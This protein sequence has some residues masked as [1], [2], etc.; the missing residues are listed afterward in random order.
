MLPP[1]ISQRLPQRMGSALQ[2]ESQVGRGSAFWFDLL[3]PI[4][5][6]SLDAQA[7]P[8]RSIISYTGPRRKI[9]VV[10]DS[11]YN[12][13]FLVDLPPE[14]QLAAL[15]EL[16]SIGDISAC[17]PTRPKSP[18]TIQHCALL[19]INWALSQPV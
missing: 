17:K 4:D 9:L 15:F 3:V 16:A 11:A 5:R 2:V 13:A 6:S 14:E 1:P 7:F 19:R 10:D 8:D 18:N 12:R